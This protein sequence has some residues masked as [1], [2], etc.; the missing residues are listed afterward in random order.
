MYKCVC[1]SVLLYMHLHLTLKGYNCAIN[2][3]LFYRK[4]VPGFIIYR[5]APCTSDYHRTPQDTTGHPRT[6]YFSLKHTN[7]SCFY[8]KKH[9]GNNIYPSYITLSSP[10]SFKLGTSCLIMPQD[11]NRKPLG[12]TLLTTLCKMCGD[13]SSK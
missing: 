3:I 1:F 11:T 10:I 8:C 13:I 4:L 7:K 9:Q 6:H 5:C 12:H 2:D